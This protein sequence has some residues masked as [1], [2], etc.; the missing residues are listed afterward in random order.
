MEFT[1]LL[2]KRTLEI[3]FNEIPSNE[4]SLI[5]ARHRSLQPRDRSLKIDS[6]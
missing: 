4:R 2:R 3:P 1:I 6:T 5:R